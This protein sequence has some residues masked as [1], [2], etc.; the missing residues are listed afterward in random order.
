[1]LTRLRKNL[2]IKNNRKEVFFLFK[3]Y[4]SRNQK[5]TEKNNNSLEYWIYFSDIKILISKLQN[6]PV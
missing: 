1:M 4:Y 3:Q 2:K 6:N 5:F